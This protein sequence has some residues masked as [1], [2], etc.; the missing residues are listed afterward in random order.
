MKIKFSG[1]LKVCGL[2]FFTTAVYAGPSEDLAKCDELR[3][4]ACGQPGTP[5][6]KSVQEEIDAC[7]LE[8]KDAAGR[9]TK[10][11]KKSTQ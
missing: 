7:K 5:S 11:K 9:K 3:P 6:C 2:V 8:V 4:R 1:V 10:E